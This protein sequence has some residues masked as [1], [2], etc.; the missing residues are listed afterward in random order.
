M[1]QTRTIQ[2]HQD[3]FKKLLA[4]ARPLEQERQVSCFVEG[5]RE[6]IRTDVRANKPRTLSAAIGLARLYEARDLT[7]W[8]NFP[9]GSRVNQPQRNTPVTQASL[10][11]KRL[12]VEELSERR[13]KR[14]VFQVQ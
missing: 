13:K 3:K 2:D 6:S 8:K 9:L 5:L 11:V 1:Q 14:F 10:P 7:Q 12:T 4:K